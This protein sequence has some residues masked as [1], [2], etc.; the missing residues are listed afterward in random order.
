MNITKERCLV[1]KNETKDGDRTYYRTTI[2]RRNPD[3]TYENAPIT[4]RFKKGVD[5]DDK[6]YIKVKDGFLTFYKGKDGKPVFEV[7]VT[8]FEIV[9]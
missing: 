3:G 4:V 1:F 2:S 6:T 9:A 8:D 5:L 7:V